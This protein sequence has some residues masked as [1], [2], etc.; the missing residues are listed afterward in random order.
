MCGHRVLRLLTRFTQLILGV[1]DMVGKPC[2]FPVSISFRCG[3]LCVRAIIID[4]VVRFRIFLYFAAVVS[5]NKV[6]ISLIIS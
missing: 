1:F 2:F 6:W 5:S 3:I 4:I